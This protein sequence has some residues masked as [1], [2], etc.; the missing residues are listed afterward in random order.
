MKAKQI[1]QLLTELTLEEKANLVQGHDSWFTA[2]VERLGISP[3]MLTDGPTGLRKQASTGSDPDLNHSV[4]AVTFPSSALIASTFD[5]QAGYELGSQLGQ[6]AR[7]EQV[8]VVLA[9]A[10]NIKR[11]PLAGRNFE[12]FS[13]DPYLTGEL[14]TAVT[15]GIQHQGVAACLK[16]FAANN[17]EN[18]RFT[19]S[20]EVDERTLRELYLLP[21]EWVVKDAY[22]AAI[23]CSYN[24]INGTL[25]SQNDWLLTS[26]LRDEWRFGG[27]VMS[28]WGAVVDRIASL[29]AGL[30]LEMPGSNPKTATEIVA[31][32]HNGQLDEATLDAAVTKVLQL[33]QE[34]PAQLTTPDA[35]TLDEQHQV[36]RQLATVG[37]VLLKNE[38]AVLPLHQ[39]EKIGVIGELAEK[40]RYQG[41]GSSQTNPFNLVTPLESLQT[42]SN[43]VE[44]APGYH[45]DQSTPDAELEQAALQIAS[46]VDKVVVFAGLPAW[47]ES[48]GIDRD[49]LLLPANQSALITKLAEVNANLIIVLQNASVIQMPWIGQAKGILETYFAGEAVG[50][51]TVDV[52]SGQVN[53]SGRLAETF[54]VRLED[55]PTFG[56]FDVNA[57]TEIYHEGL[58]VGYRY[59]DKK[60]LATQ[61]PFGFG[62]SYTHFDYENLRI[63]EQDEHVEVA[64][65]VTNTGER[66]GA[67][68]VQ[69]YL[70]NQVS[71]IEKPE[72]GLVGFR[73]VWLDPH[74]TK[75]VLVPVRKTDFAYYN[76]QSGMW[77]T[78]NGSYR[79]TVCRNVETPV[80]AEEF[81]VTWGQDPQPAVSLDSYMIDV[82]KRP[83]I[84]PAL[85]ESHLMKVVKPFIS[86]KVPSATDKMF[87]SMPL[88][89]Y[90]ML[91]ASEAEINSFIKLANQATTAEQPDR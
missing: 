61:F 50:E 62:L 22:P 1:A 52:L 27:L 11:S 43:S 38:D 65:D 48:E 66:Y 37:M 8:S 77:E 47:A 12:Y 84:I 57:S 86:A 30:D 64:V 5:S 44:Y 68:V 51:A 70:S 19:N 60:Q 63:N 26:I 14:A 23:M 25:N 15:R 16:H 45:V 17:R 83:G 7:N 73:K 3:I 72:K 32:V 82:V 31:A 10:M 35:P 21:F 46:H 53:P 29:K 76:E 28:D 42:W 89:V 79:L 36:S 18:Y 13:E 41:G 80:L 88:R 85:E 49:D 90:P 75:T 33:V 9:P 56:S 71:A 78:D 24:A 34:Y 67:E 91:G 87:L 2:G 69:V 59:Y 39:Q 55:N 20:S 58:L 54:P 4:P 40:P 81:Q 6:A 74:E